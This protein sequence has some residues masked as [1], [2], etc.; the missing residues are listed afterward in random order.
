MNEHDNKDQEHLVPVL[1]LDERTGERSV[2]FVQDN[3]YPVDDLDKPDYAPAP[4][5]GATQDRGEVEDGRTH[6]GTKDV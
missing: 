1:E 6:D 5:K 2:V 4:G 3:D